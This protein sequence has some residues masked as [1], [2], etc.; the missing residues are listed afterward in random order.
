[1][2][3]FFITM[4]KKRKRKKLSS[5][6]KMWK[7][8]S[9]IRVSENCIDSK[10]YMVG[11]TGPRQLYLFLDTELVR[12]RITQNCPLNGSQSCLEKDRCLW[13]LLASP[14]PFPWEGRAS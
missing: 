1:M 8:P 6:K 3:H 9:D 10:S 2:K 11:K 13:I 4:R 5:V 12:T 14:Y 7:Y